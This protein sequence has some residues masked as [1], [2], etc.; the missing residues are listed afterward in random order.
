MATVNLATAQV[1]VGAAAASAVAST[2]TYGFTLGANGERIETTTTTNT[3]HG[4]WQGSNIDLNNLTLNSEGQD[5]NIRGSRLNVSGTTTFD[6]TKDVNV[7][8]GLENNR[9]ESSSKTNTQSMSYNSGGG[10]SI[11]I[12]K[13]NSDSQKE[14]LKHI[15]SEVNLNQTSGSINTLKLQGGEVSIA[16]RANLKINNIHIESQQDTASSSNS[17]QGGSIGGGITGNISA[18]Y[19]QGKGNSASAWVNNTSKLLIGKLNY[20]GALELKYIQDHSTESNRGFNISTSIGKSVKGQDAESIKFPNGSTTVG[21]QST[22]NEKE[23]LT[24]AMMGQVSV[25]SSTTT[26]NLDINYTQEITRDQVTVMLNGSVTVDLRILN[27]SGRAQI[28][29]EQKDKLENLKS[30]A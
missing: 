14:S 8:A 1:A 3:T 30:F 16:D 29:Q 26:S 24:K 27:E 9:Q 17:S 28:I 22:G 7:F 6:G 11:S 21:L 20:T 15:N 10:G 4:K 13:Q 18:S 12:G 19:N 2:A 25:T 5:V 23:Q